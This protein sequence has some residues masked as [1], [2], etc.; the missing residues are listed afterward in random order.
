MEVGEEPSQREFLVVF[1]IPDVWG[2]ELVMSKFVRSIR[3]F[4]QQ[5]FTAFQQYVRIVLGARDIVHLVHFHNCF[6]KY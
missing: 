1:Q 6:L 5:I 2:D 3:S 4:I